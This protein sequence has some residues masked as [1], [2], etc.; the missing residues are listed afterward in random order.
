MGDAQAPGVLNDAG[1]SAIPPMRPA[2]NKDQRSRA[3][4]ALVGA[5]TGDALG[6]P[7][8]F[9]PPIASS[10]DVEMT[11]GGHFN[12]EPGEWT[13]DTSM[14]VVILQVAAE[15]GLGESLTSKESLDAIAAGWYRWSRETVDIGN[16][17]ADVFSQALERAMA[18]GRSIPS[19]MDMRESARA[20]A[21]TRP[22]SSGNGGLMRTYAV[23][24][25][26]VRAADS[27][28]VSAV[29]VLNELTHVE[30][31]TTI[32]ALLWSFALRRAI[33]DGV[34]DFRAGVHVLD[35]SERAHWERIIDQAH[36]APPSYFKRNGW[37][38]HAFQAAIAS[39]HQAGAIPVDKF[40]RRAWFRRVVEGAV[41]AGYD[42]DTVAS[43]AGALA[44][45]AVGYKAVDPL[46][47]RDLHG[48]PGM[49]VEELI[50]LGERVLARSSA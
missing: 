40:E 18:D 24:L 36:S 29:T 41:R 17:T 2:L 43:I 1:A 23:V 15:P 35:E 28:L 46:W 3:L 22:Q 49:D 8:E 50:A 38:R 16:L 19:G 33:L 4:G 27:D 31:D 42:T 39:I 32:A 44:A 48:W 7:Y 12:W 11:G 10:D 30:R 5:A 14:A 20:L 37:V 45:A 47:R 9:E 6:A 25:S 34:I 13:D 26:M 21:R